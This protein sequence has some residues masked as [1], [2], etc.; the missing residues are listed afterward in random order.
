[1]FVLAH[2][3]DPHLAPLPRPQVYELLG[4]RIGG[5]FNWHRNR[6]NLHLTAVLD[7]LTADVAAQHPDHLAVTGDLVNLSL[8]AE[9]A[10]ARAW[11]ERLGPAPDVTLVPGNHDTYV[12]SKARHPERF[13]G[14]FMRGDEPAP[15]DAPVFPFVRRRGP[16]ALIGLSTA[17]PAPPFRAT[18]MLG[19]AQL[20]RFAEL[21]ER[22]RGQ[23]FRVVLIH[24]PPV[25]PPERHHERLIDGPAFLDVLKAHGA[26]LVLHGHAHVHMLQWFEGPQG[27][28]PAIG[29]PAA[30]ATVGGRYE[31]AA[32][33]LYAIDGAPGAWRCQMT[34]R[35]LAPDGGSIIERRRL[36]LSG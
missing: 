25:S 35:G 8:A 36:V 26:E 32:Y 34:A 20:A 1:M 16:V 7:R 12:R 28:V 21:A 2:L 3:S 5:F 14:D 4:K 10:P 22:L 18:G 23:A 27:R 17:V 13:W 33:N 24:H 30:S 6:R 11:L 15:T 19:T 9:F 29:V 31:A